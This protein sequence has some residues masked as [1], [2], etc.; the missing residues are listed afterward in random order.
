MRVFWL[1]ALSACASGPTIES[2][3][4]TTSIV[5]TSVSVFGTG[6]TEGTTLHLQNE[7]GLRTPLESIEH[8]GLVVIRGQVPKT[9]EA[10]KYQYV[11]AAGGAEAVSQSVTITVPE[12]DIPCSGNYTANT[13]VSWARQV[14]VVDRFYKNGERETL[15]TP[16]N[17][18]ASI[19][20][21]SHPKDDK[22]C[23]AVFLNLTDGSRLRY[24]ES[25]SEDL[26]QQAFKFANEMKKPITKTQ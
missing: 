22:T 10:G 3:D 11:V 23:S 26:S 20:V 15:Q 14:V 18:V 19:E 6:F 5:G 1:L 21:V 16:F 12:P 13:Q 24:A 9:L 7:K 17:D 8:S 4:P 2:V 25:L